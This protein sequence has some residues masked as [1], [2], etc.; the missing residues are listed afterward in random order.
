MKNLFD[1][2]PKELTQD[3]FI[4]WLLENYEDKDLKELVRNFVLFLTDQKVDCS[5]DSGF[6][7]LKT[8]TSAAIFSMRG[9]T[10]F[11]V[12]S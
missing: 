7:F 11:R 4:R 2:A 9:A 5:N 6:R 12:M 10:R 3:G 8:W 1:Y